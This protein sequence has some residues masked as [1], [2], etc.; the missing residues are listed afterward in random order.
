MEMMPITE[1]RQR[2]LE[3]ADHLDENPEE[4]V[5]V[6]TKRSRPVLALMSYE[7]YQTLR[8][9]LDVVGDRQ[10]MSQLRANV[11]DVDEG[12]TTPWQRVR[13]KFRSKR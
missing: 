11:A 6:V 12:M 3:I 2:F 8:E 13:N 9:T 4:G 7:Y 1:A 10:L 5:V